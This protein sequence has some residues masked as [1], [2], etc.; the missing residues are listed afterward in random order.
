MK[1]VGKFTPFV[2]T[3]KEDEATRQPLEKCSPGYAALHALSQRKN[4]KQKNRTVGTGEIRNIIGMM[5]LAPNRIL[6]IAQTEEEYLTNTGPVAGEVVDPSFPGDPPVDD[7]GQP[8][9]HLRANLG[10][11]DEVM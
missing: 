10:G 11:S 6:V 4:Y 2:F 8:P 5:Q 3:I 9:P 1:G 7:S